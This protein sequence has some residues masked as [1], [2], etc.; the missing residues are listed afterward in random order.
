VLPC[1]LHRFLAASSRA[2]PSGG[3]DR[4]RAGPAHPPAAA[5]APSS[6]LRERRWIWARRRRAPR[7]RARDGERWPA[8]LPGGGGGEQA[9]PASV[10]CA[11]GHGARPLPC[12]LLR[13]PAEP[14]RPFPPLPPRHGPLAAPLAAPRRGGAAAAAC[15]R[16]R[17]AARRRVAGNSRGRPRRGGEAAATSSSDPEV[18]PRRISA[19]TKVLAAPWAEETERSC[20]QHWLRPTGLG[21]AGPRGGGRPAG[22]RA[23]EGGAPLVQIGG[24]A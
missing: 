2:D 12:S 1:S 24:R 11:T 23:R 13:R 10:R 22:A 5:P 8:R 9:A 19:W 7:R 20:P 15:T 4:W 21:H 17:R 6:L 18:A 16:G 3:E 14:H